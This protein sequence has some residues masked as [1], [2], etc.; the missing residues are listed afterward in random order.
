MK[1]KI[2]IIAGIVL[3]I[4]VAVTATILIINGI[5]SSEVEVGEGVI[6]EIDKENKTIN[7]ETNS[8]EF[9]TS[10][11][12]I[13]NEV[14]NVYYD[15]ECKTLIDPKLNLQEGKNVFYLKSESNPDEVWTLVVEYEFKP[16]TS[17]QIIS[18]QKE[19]KV[20]GVYVPGYLSYY[21]ED[22]EEAYEVEITLSM[23]SGFDTSKEGKKT[24][25][26][27]YK[28]FEIDLEINVK[29]LFVVTGDTLSK[30]DML[31]VAFTFLSME[32]GNDSYEEFLDTIDEL[33]EDYEDFKDDEYYKQIVDLCYDAVKETGMTSA[34][35]KTIEKE[36]KNF[37]KYVFD[38]KEELWETTIKEF[39]LYSALDDEPSQCVQNILNVISA[40]QIAY[41]GKTIFEGITLLD[42]NFNYNFEL[43][44]AE[45]DALM[46]E[47]VSKEEYQEFKENFGDFLLTEYLEDPIFENF[48]SHNEIVALSSVGE[49]SNHVSTYISIIEYITSLS[50]AE[51]DEIKEL[52]DLA[53]N[54]EFNSDMVK[55]GLRHFKGLIDEVGLPNIKQYVINVLNSNL[56]KYESDIYAQ[57]IVWL[58]VD[59]GYPVLELV[60]DF[61]YDISDNDIEIIYG[62]AENAYDLF[63][64]GSEEKALK[65]VVKSVVIL[66]DYLCPVLDGY[67]EQEL[68]NMYR[69]IS[70][71]ISSYYKGMVSV[72]DIKF[73][74]SMLDNFEAFDYEDLTD[75]NISQLRGYLFDISEY[76]SDGFGEN[77]YVNIGD[78][79][80]IEQNDK[81][82]V[83]KN[84]LDFDSWCYYEKID[85]NQGKYID[86]D[87]SFNDLTYI[88]FDSS[89]PGAH[90]VRVDYEG[91]TT[92]IPYW[93]EPTTI[94]KDYLYPLFDDTR[95]I[96]YFVYQGDTIPAVASDPYYDD[97]KRV[98]YYYDLTK[99]VYRIELE[100]LTD[101]SEVVGFDSETPGLHAGYYYVEHEIL[102]EV[103]VPISYYV[104]TDEPQLTSHNVYNSS[105]YYVGY[106]GD[107]NYY[108]DCEYDYE[109]SFTYNGSN[110]VYSRNYTSEEYCTLPNHL[111][112]FSKPGTV[113]YEV[114][115]NGTTFDLSFEI[116]SFEEAHTVDHISIY[117]LYYGIEFDLSNTNNYRLDTKFGSS[118]SQSYLEFLI[119]ET[120]LEV[121]V[122]YEDFYDSNYY[123]C[124]I[125]VYQFGRLVYTTERN[126][127]ITH[128]FLTSYIKNIDVVLK[129][130]S[131]IYDNM[132]IDEFF[133][134]IE[135]IYYEIHYPNGQVETVSEYN[136]EVL[137]NYF[138][139]YSNYYYF[140]LYHY[141]SGYN[142]NFYTDN[143][144]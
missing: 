115:H 30:N 69:F 48:F 61:I 29:P 106:D 114:V 119:D 109:Y 71:L 75:D 23:L 104:F 41:I 133:E 130:D 74:V 51:R 54:E 88:G 36:I 112:D 46:K 99:Q 125:E 24:V 142:E 129:T 90:F 98:S 67:S 80:T 87:I 15:K 5:K 10:T 27:T 136:P 77:L 97:Y 52:V 37:A 85:R 91:A 42:Y 134:E 76:F 127:Y 40:D 2:F 14:F 96:S 94:D 92:Y 107:V 139:Y 70:A 79:V 45:Y 73:I 113:N 32:Y 20:G 39:T 137:M 82:S 25:K 135:Y 21:D 62:L 12:K 6:A 59:E 102:G 78:M 50:S 34:D 111:F 124:T 17:S 126:I 3:F 81:I 13:G 68:D 31:S 4:A 138:S 84:A 26:V 35:A 117:Q 8:F 132:T 110:W 28:D 66:A 60:Y 49:L 131:H 141:N 86:E 89:T 118:Y 1:K 56:I 64:K 83:L 38:N 19:Y 103:L 9:D 22:D 58:I 43:T 55:V 100:T 123:N 121:N 120:D 33:W 65:E 116:F 63:D 18:W 93:V 144:Y 47:C 7:V 57:A 140:I 95:N 53:Y 105:D 122:I 108:Y 128:L 44:W 101:L 72:N 143:Y 11:I 16:G